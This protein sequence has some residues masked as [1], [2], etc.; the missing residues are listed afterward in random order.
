MW[1]WD[2]FFIFVGE[3]TSSKDDCQFTAKGSIYS[4]Q[5]QPKET[6]IPYMVTI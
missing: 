3:N 6:Q 1:S 5:N 4:Y 2:L